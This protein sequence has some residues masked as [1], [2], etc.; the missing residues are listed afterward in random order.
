MKT[1]SELLAEMTEEKKDEFINGLLD[2][3]N[4]CPEGLINSEWCQFDTDEE[5]KVTRESLCDSAICWWKYIKEA[6]K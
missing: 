5:C 2:M 4:G 1:L 6:E 3:I